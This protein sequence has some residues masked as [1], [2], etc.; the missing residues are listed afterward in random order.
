MPYI[1][2]RLHMKNRSCVET[3]EVGECLYMRC[4]PKVVDNPY[5]EISI[6]E[7]SHNRAGLA[8]DILSVPED[9]LYSIKLDE[10]FEKYEGKVIC[11]LEIKSLT[12]EHKYHKTFTQEKNG[13]LYTSVIELL[14]D[15]EECMYPHSVFRVWL[16][17]E[18]ITK[19]NFGKTIGKLN[20]IRTELK[21]ELASM[22]KRKQV[23]QDDVPHETR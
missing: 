11:T 22:I 3:F 1:P 6:A 12:P 19:D 15:P 14:H 21:E 7:L 20:K 5:K 2:E 13:E 10:P 9:V 8:A 17:G 16:N 23:H 18:T 4:N